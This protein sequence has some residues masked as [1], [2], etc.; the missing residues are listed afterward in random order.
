MAPTQAGRASVFISYSRNDAAVL[1]RLKRF[2]VPLERAGTVDYWDDTRIEPGM[3]WRQEIRRALATAKVAILLISADFLASK[4]I[5][6]DEL[7]PPRCRR[8]R[9]YGDPARDNRAK[10]FFSN[11]EPIQVSSG[12]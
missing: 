2:L 3:D 12:K 4:F 1:R 7:P 6:E 9:G 8:K 10:S 5:I 11:G